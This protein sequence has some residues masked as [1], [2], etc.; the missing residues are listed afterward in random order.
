MKIVEHKTSSPANYPKLGVEAPSTPTATGTLLEVV[1]GKKAWSLIVGKGAEGRS[2]Y[3]RKPDQAQSELVEPNVT[4]DP[5]TQKESV[6]P[7]FNSIFIM[8]DSGARGSQQQ[9][10]QLAGR[11]IS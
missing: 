9:M 5:E 7:S 11:R 8:A 1:A 6:E 3:V 2:L 10:R 4:A